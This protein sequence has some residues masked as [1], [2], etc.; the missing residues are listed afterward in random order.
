MSEK[1]CCGEEIEGTMIEC[2][3]TNK[4]CPGRSWYH[5][6]CVNLTEEDLEK[7]DVF[8]CQACSTKTGKTTKFY[9]S[10]ILTLRSNNSNQSDEEEEEEFE[11]AGIHDHGPCDVNK[12]RL[13]LLVEW[14]GFP[15]K[16]DFTWE[17]EDQLIKCY[18]IVKAYKI[19]H[20]L[21]DTVLK[22]VGGAANSRIHEIKNWVN[23]QQLKA[24]LLRQLHH[25]RYKTDLKVTVKHFMEKVSLNENAIV[26]ILFENHYYTILWLKDRETAFIAD[27]NNLSEDSEILSIFKKK[28]NLGEE[29]KSIKFDKRTKVDYC[30]SAA[31]LIAL[32]FSRMYK[33]RDFNYEKIEVP[34]HLYE[35]VS[36][37]LHQKESSPQEGKFDI[38]KVRPYLKCRFCEF[39]T[40]K[41]RSA[42]V[43]HEL[44]KCLKKL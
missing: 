34:K 4:Q 25:D 5:L 1:Y 44:K 15:N 40:K 28:L 37:A 9:P 12:K 2:D 7:I 33:H 21:G 22:P 27:G 11:I 6:S 24:I 41:G 23:P 42:L 30:A 3:S 43:N 38:K 39:V 18:D 8:I 29:L 36:K 10:T 13:K 14:K 26:V 20:R 35:R 16:S 19:K 32:E 17:Y 31:V